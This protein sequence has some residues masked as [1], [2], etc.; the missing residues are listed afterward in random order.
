MYIYKYT[1]IQREPI[2]CFIYIH[3]HREPIVCFIYTHTHSI[4]S[5]YLENSD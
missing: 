1:H 4:D 2:V 5:V 3:T